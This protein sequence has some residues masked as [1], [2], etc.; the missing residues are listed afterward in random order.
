M[1]YKTKY[2]PLD[3]V[4]VIV[5]RYTENPFYVVEGVIRYIHIDKNIKYSIGWGK[6]VNE[7]DCFLNEE[8]AWKEA[9]KRN[10]KL[11]KWVSTGKNLYHYPFGKYGYYDRLERFKTEEEAQKE[12]EKRNKEIM[13]DNKI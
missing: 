13:G 4:F 3:R 11:S 8:D 10:S 12:C 9:K 2:K 5:T 1:V 7:N 6:L